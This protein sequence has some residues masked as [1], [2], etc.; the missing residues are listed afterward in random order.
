MVNNYYQEKNES[1][2]CINY[3]DKINYNN[4]SQVYVIGI[5]FQYGV[6]TKVKNDILNYLEQTSSEMSEKISTV[7]DYLN[8]IPA[9]NKINTPYVI[10]A[11]KDNA[12]QHFIRFWTRHLLLSDEKDKIADIWNDAIT[13]ADTRNLS[14]SCLCL[15]DGQVIT[16]DYLADAIR[17]VFLLKL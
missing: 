4:L 8:S 14:F 3:K 12:K 2:N 13:Y 17:D 5:G 6:L 7:V 9:T 1:V 15:D 10:Y 11:N 16:S